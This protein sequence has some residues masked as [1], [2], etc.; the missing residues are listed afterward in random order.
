MVAVVGVGARA[1]L[2]LHLG[3][4]D[5]LDVAE[6]E[7]LVAPLRRLATPQGVDGVEDLPLERQA[8]IAVPL[9][10]PG[11]HQASERVG[12]QVD[13]VVDVADGVPDQPG[14]LSLV[15]RGGV[16]ALRDGPTATLRRWRHLSPP[17][18]ERA[19]AHPGG[20]SR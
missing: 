5:S 18:S 9:A 8:S 4:R 2:L 11:A 13:E 20:P 7:H 16:V 14:E 15:G 12:L 6:H 17:S 1:E 3:W 19:A 10:L